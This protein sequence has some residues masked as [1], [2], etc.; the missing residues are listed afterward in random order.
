MARLPWGQ[1][2]SE[3]N[4]L[5][6]TET[7]ECVVW[8]YAHINVRGKKKYGKVRLDGE[9]TYT[10]RHALVLATGEDPADKEAAHLCKQTLCM[11]ARH[12]YWASP[13]ENQLDR[14]RDG[15]DNRGE[16]HPLAKL[17]KDDVL[18][19]RQSAEPQRIT[20]KRFGISQ[21]HVSAI[22]TKKLWAHL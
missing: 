14:R 5:R 4:R 12:L 16:K 13:S 22:Q 17:T 20:A 9:L 21:Q 19:I 6:A 11:N 2:L 10:H 3:F 1:A 18:A 15:T 7:D 8:P